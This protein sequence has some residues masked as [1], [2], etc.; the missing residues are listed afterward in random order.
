MRYNFYIDIGSGYQQA[1]PDFI[2]KFKI[3][4][5]IGVDDIEKYFYRI[6]WGKIQFSNKP[7]LY[8]Q[9][10]SNVYRIFDFIQNNTLGFDTK[11][12]VKFTTDNF[13]VIG[14]FGKND[15]TFDYDRKIL[16]VTPA[17]VDQ[18]T[19]I[20][21]NWESE[22]NFDEWEFTNNTVT[23]EITNTELETIQDWPYPSITVGGQPYTPRNLI[24]EKDYVD[25][26]GL[27]LYFDGNKPK[28]T[29]YEDSYY[30]FEGMHKIYTSIIEEFGSFSL[31]DRIEILGQEPNLVNALTLPI[32]YG[33][34][35]LSK[36]RVYEGTRTG[37]LS[38]KR[39]RQLYCETW[40]SREEEIKIDVID[41]SNEYGFE[42]PVGEGWHMRITRIKGGKNAHLW[43]RKPFGGAYSESWGVPVE[44]QNNG[45]KNF[46]WNWY[47]YLET[48]LQY[49]NSANTIAIESTI[50]LR[51][52]FEHILNNTHSS[53]S[54]MQ[55]K[56]TFFFNDLEEELEVLNGTDGY[57]YVT[58]A[59]NY[60]NGLKLFFTKDLTVPGD[61]EVGA[62]PR[63]TLRSI[64]EDLNKVFIN[65]LTWFIDENGY[66][67]IEHVRWVDLR[68]IPLDISTDE[69]LKFTT[70]WE[71]DKAIMFEEYFYNQINSGYIDF[72]KNSVVFNKIVSNN[73]NTD[74]KKE[75]STSLISTDARYCILNSTEIKEGIILITVDENDIVLNKTGII[76]GVVETNGYLAL[77]NILYDFGRY[78]GMWHTGVMNGFNVFFTVTERN[79]LGTELKLKGLKKSLFYTTQIGIGLIDEG[80]IDFENE[81]TIIKLRYRYNSNVNGDV[82]ALVF[83]KES[84]FVGAVNNWADIDNYV[85]NT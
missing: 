73:R 37:G 16:T 35:E 57:N 74:L 20:L 8:S 31:L 33:D 12:T 55:F 84:D 25:N 24:K 56:S 9:T 14:Y 67:R 78:E 7:Y 3:T 29:L 81:N 30:R 45:T 10:N 43:T 1:Y 82:F 51:D 40:F 42:S 41:P 64:L 70:Y 72:T 77:S 6:L 46:S 38:G 48:S 65:K 18:Y 80:E 47:K 59:K 34:Y 32:E 58:G 85:I 79:K 19:D 50:N 13:E 66:F 11:I 2:D 23:V 63:F 61:D 44:V 76:S 62:Y 83:Q 68:K 5:K 54:A 21:E 53:L 49:D 71:Y 26:S 22:V 27:Y 39:W 36:F 60:L 69:L 15:C 17:T 4:R 28:E 75:Y 52:F